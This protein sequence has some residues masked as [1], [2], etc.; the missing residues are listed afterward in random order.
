MRTGH[1]GKIDRDGYVYYKNRLKERINFGNVIIFPNDIESAL[2][3]HANVAN[4]SVFSIKNEFGIDLRAC[5]WVILKDEAINT[6]VEEL[7]SIC[8]SGS[9]QHIKFVHDFPINENGKICKIK[10]SNL[11]KLELNI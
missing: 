8:G 5:A 11:Y 3:T 7:R 10:M 2:R 9:I 4:A 6:S 1:F